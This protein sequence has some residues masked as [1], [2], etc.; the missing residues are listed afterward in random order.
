MADEPIPED[1]RE[2]ILKQ[3]DSLAQL[4]A[5]LLLRADPK[6][7]WD[8]CRIANRLYISE[9][10]VSSALARLIDAGLLRVERNSFRYQPVPATEALIDRVATTY[11]NH[12]AAVAKLIQTKPRIQQF[13]D[14]FRFR[15]DR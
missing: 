6:Q 11:P 4:E 8:I 7:S 3:V 13:A 10:E 15:R 5:L 12:V 14:A 2:Y 1:V 9:P